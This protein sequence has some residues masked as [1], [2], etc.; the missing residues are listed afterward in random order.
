M[1]KLMTKEDLSAMMTEMMKAQ[2]PE[3][4][5]AVK[6][7]LLKMDR[8]ALFPQMEGDVDKGDAGAQTFAGSV[9][10][11]SAIKS[12]DARRA[13]V[14]NNTNALGVAFVNSC[15]PW[16][17]LS[18]A[19]EGFAKLLK[20]RM[21][22]AQLASGFDMN[23]YKTLCDAQYK[24]TGM[25]EGVNPDGGFTVPI[26]FAATVVEFAIQMSPILKM[27]WRV[28]MSAAQIKYPK[29]SQS[30]GNYFG[31]VVIT[32]SGKVA[33]SEGATLTRTKPT[34][35][36]NVF[37]AKKVQAM[38][39][40]TDELIQ[41]SLINIVNYV[42]GVIT[43]AYWY[44][45]ERVIIEGNGTNEPLGIIT[46]PVVKA[47]A[48]KRTTTGLVKDTDLYCL[49]GAMDENF[50]DLYWITRRSTIASIR[51]LKDTVG[52]PLLHE[53]WDTQ[54]STPN[55][56][57]TILGYPY[58]VTRNAHAM[59]HMGDVIIGDLGYYMLAVRNDMRIDMSDAPYWT[60]DEYAVRFIARC[61]G[62]PGSSYAF[63]ILSG[64]GS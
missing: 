3:L 32:W 60:S 27:I 40:L 45:L 59:G 48:V 44:D 16:K 43:R 62:M 11:F 30:D 42:T 23:G 36:Q 22:P 53:G 29:L 34:F 56:V 12:Y 33:S 35:D 31:G 5:K 7:E 2:T 47:N 39:V 9:V 26:E 25:S 8:K 61:D 10:D 1:E 20:T 58:H 19:M 55:L 14:D 63:K 50:R 46:D 38:T 13:L 41:D 52:Q 51:A 18:P 4:L 49:E 21:R 6:D 64:T 15:G 17:K 24:A 57:K 28:P 37:N 54:Q